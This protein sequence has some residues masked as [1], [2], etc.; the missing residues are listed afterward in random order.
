MWIREQSKSSL[1]GFFFGSSRLFFASE[2]GWR[3]HLASSSLIWTS[4]SPIVARSI[5]ASRGCHSTPSSSRPSDDKLQ[6][7]FVLL[8]P[9]IDISLAR[10]SSWSLGT[11]ATDSSS[12]GLYSTSSSFLFCCLSK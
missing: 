4:Q 1:G 9:W 8:Q 2:K 11:S 10:T 12:F 7:S 3:V 6:A 5:A